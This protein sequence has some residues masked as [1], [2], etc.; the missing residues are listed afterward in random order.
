[1][2]EYMRKFF[3]TYKDQPTIS[4]LEMSDNHEGSTEVPKFIDGIM[5]EHFEKLIDGKVL[6]GMP[7]IFLADHG[8]HLTLTSSG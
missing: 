4:S 8:L 3:K 6:D 2:M 1:M 7:M 5:K